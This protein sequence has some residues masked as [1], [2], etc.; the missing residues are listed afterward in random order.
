MIAQWAF[1]EGSGQTAADSA[2]SND[3]TLGTTAGVDSSD[4]AWACAAGGSALDFDGTDDEVSLSGVTIGNSAAWTIACQEI[5]RFAKDES[6]SHMSDLTPKEREILALICQAKPNK[7]IARELDMNEK[8]VRNHA[9][10]IF[11]KLGVS[12]RQEAIVKMTGRSL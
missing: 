5:L 4:P 2:G 6:S 10:H 8:T 1:D 7:Q 3:G 9:T 11:A 12:T